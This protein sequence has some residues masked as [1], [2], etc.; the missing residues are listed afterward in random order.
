MGMWIDTRRCVQ[1]FDIVNGRMRGRG[2]CSE[3]AW[4]DGG[5]LASLGNVVVRVRGVT[6]HVGLKKPGWGCVGLMLPRDEWHLR[7]RCGRQSAA[8]VW[9][10]WLGASDRV[11][12][13]CHVMYLRHVSKSDDIIR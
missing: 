8:F 2:M 10:P 3:R 4:R 13:V 9:H 12:Y 11:V 7:G 5:T 1:L 6:S